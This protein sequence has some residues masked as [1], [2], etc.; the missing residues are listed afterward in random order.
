[1]IAPWYIAVE[2]FSPSWGDNWT[3]YIHF[4]GLIQLEEVVSLDASLCPCVIKELED[5]DW[6]HNVQEDYVTAF[7]RDLEYLLRR[8]PKINP[9]NIL[10]AVRNP[11]EECRTAFPNPRFEFKGYDLVEEGVGMSALTNCGG[12]PLAFRNEEL[13]SAG[14]IAVLPRALE[15]QKSLRKHYPDDPHADCDIWALWKMRQETEPG[16]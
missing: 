5:E 4:S 1:M 14:L 7:F 11:A 10:A 15:V 13:S 8:V 6:N 2:S 9:V 3:K 16:V 12:F